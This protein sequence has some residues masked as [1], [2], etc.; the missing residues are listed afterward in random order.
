MKPKSLIRQ[1]APT[2]L[3]DATIER[4]LPAIALAAQRAD[5]DA[6][7]VGASKFGGAPDVPAGFAWPSWDERPLSFMAQINLE[8]IA[9]FDI[10][11]K[12]SASGLLLFF[13][14]MADEDGMAV[15]RTPI[16]RAVGA[17]CMSR[18]N[19]RAPRCPT[20]R[21]TNP[22]SKPPLSRRARFGARQNI[23]ITSTANNGTIGP[24]RILTR[25]SK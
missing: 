7:A 5:D 25:G 8:E 4:L 9:P 2:R 11:N 10:E 14:F 1:H 17:S 3:Q 15:G 20:E 12:L 6:I 22:R 24:M 16:K 13:Y 23:P 18:A 19:Y 21:T